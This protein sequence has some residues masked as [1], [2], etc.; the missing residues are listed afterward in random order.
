MSASGQGSRNGT[1]RGERFVLDAVPSL[2]R[3]TVVRR[4]PLRDDQERQRSGWPQARVLLVDRRGRAQVTAD[5]GDL[6]YTEAAALGDEPPPGAV[7][8]GEYGGWAYWAMRTEREP[9]QGE[10]WTDLRLGGG[11]LSD[12][13]AGLLVSAVALLNWQHRAR[14]CQRCGNVVEITRAGWASW[15]AHCSREDYPRTDPAVICLVHDD[16]GPNGQHVLLARQPQWPAHLYSV[17]A[18]FVEAGESL[19]ATVHR[20]ICEEVGVSVH[21]VRYLG[22]QPWPFPRSLMLGFDAVAEASAVPDPADGEI[23]AARWVSRQTLRAAIEAR[24]EV[25]DGLMMP[26]N[27]SIAAT[28]LRSWAAVG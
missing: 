2:S 16:D 15:C 27:S 14:F 8:L 7:L 3:S 9:G 18:G 1:R 17:L 25:V 23:E 12:T 5:G 21:S 13:A 24:G 20:E 4:E 11:L 22:S 19:E 26:G 6:V 10:T 28:M